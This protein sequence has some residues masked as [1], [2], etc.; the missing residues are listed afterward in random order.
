MWELVPS[1]PIPTISA[2]SPMMLAAIEVIGATVVTTLNVA[3]EES[4]ESELD[5]QAAASVAMTVRSVRR[6]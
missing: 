2:R 1:G 3:S 6:R 4:S 5:P